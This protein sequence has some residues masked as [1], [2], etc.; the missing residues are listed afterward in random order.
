MRASSVLEYLNR[1]VVKEKYVVRRRLDIE[2]DGDGKWS[3]LS[4]ITTDHRRIPIMIPQRKKKRIDPF[5][6][7]P[8]FRDT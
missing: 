7:P 3:S 4:G 8:S 1:A 6:N 2:R 5:R